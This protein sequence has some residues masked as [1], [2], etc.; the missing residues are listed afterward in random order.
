[1]REK[2]FPN[3]YFYAEIAPAFP[4]RDVLSVISEKGLC[5]NETPVFTQHEPVSEVREGME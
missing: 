3:F 5:T 4:I 1:M 2:K